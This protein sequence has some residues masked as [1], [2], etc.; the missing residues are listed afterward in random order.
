[1]GAIPREAS[2]DGGD[3]EVLAEFRAVR[4]AIGNRLRAFFGTD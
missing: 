1:M 4:D 3:E 2:A